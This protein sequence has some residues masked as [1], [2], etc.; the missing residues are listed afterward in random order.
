MSTRPLSLPPLGCLSLFAYYLVCATLHK[1]SSGSSTRYFVVY[2][3]FC[4]AYIDDLLVAS[5]SPEEHLQHLQLVFKQLQEHGVIINPH[6]CLFGVPEVD[7]L[8]HH[9]SFDGITPLP[10]KDS[11]RDMLVHHCPSFPPQSRDS[12]KSMWTWLALCPQHADTHIFSL[13][14][15]GSH[16]GQRPCPYQTSP[17]RPLLKH[18]SVGGLPVTVSLHLSSLTE[19]VSLN[20]IFGDNL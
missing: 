2:I 8:G 12:T 19:A 5:T 16:N 4:Y 10:D 14:L 7:F 11:D 13:V 3:D 20:Q 1:R 18:L 6:K 15:T 17:P 9:N